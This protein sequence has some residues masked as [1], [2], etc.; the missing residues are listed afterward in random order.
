MDNN[1]T[2]RKFLG[3][4]WIWEH[5]GNYTQEEKEALL[6]ISYCVPSNLDEEEE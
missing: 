5:R 6:A 1:A 3:L 4:Y 2:Q